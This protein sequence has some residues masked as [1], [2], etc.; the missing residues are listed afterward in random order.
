MLISK[1]QEVGITITFEDTDDFNVHV[2]KQD[3]DLKT[4]TVYVTEI[5]DDKPAEVTT[6]TLVE[7]LKQSNENN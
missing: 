1:E 6:E 5:Q 2:T 4:Y 3:P 7:I